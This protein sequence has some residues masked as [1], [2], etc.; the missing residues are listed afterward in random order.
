MKS[1]NEGV[2][3]E[4]LKYGDK[5]ECGRFNNGMFMNY[6]GHGI[7][8]AES[9]EMDD[10]TKLQALIDG[11]GYSAGADDAIQGLAA[12]GNF[13]DGSSGFLVSLAS[14]IAELPVRED[15]GWPRFSA[16]TLKD[17]GL[18]VAASLELP[19]WQHDMSMSGDTITMG[20]LLQLAEEV[21][22]ESIQ[23]KKFTPEDLQKQ[24]SELEPGN[25][26]GMMWIELKLMYCKDEEDEAVMRPV[27]NN[28][29]P[30]VKTTSVREYLMK[31][32]LSNLT[33]R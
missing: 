26:M 3:E 23:V 5:I 7:F 30:K 29:C 19:K 17:V 13:Q 32:W 15:G 27:L 10:E 33:R 14:S 25:Y 31:A 4:C 2:W 24:L 6:L 18:F 28:L 8:S 20:E 21:S 12:E 1:M 16:T 9:Q 11:H 22:G